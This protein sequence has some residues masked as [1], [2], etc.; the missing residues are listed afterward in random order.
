[1]SARSIRRSHQRRLRRVATATGAALGGSAL[2]ASGAQAVN[3]PVSNTNNAGAGS[4][5]GAILAANAAGGPDTISFNAGVSGEITLTTGEIPITDDLTITGPGAG[6]LSVSG[7]ANNNNVRDFATGAG[8]L[9][10]SR[11]F[12][13]DDPSAPGA[14][15]MRVTISGLTLREGVADDWVAGIQARPGGAIY[16]EDTDL[17]L[18][19]TTMSD[20]VATDDGG[21]LFAGEAD[22]SSA[23]LSITGSQFTANRALSEGGAV[24]SFVPKY[25]F[26]DEGTQITDTVISGNR[27]GGNDFGGVT[28]S[29]NPEGGGVLA[30]YS[31]EVTRVTIANNVA[32]T[33]ATDGSAGGI[34]IGTGS[35]TDSVVSGNSAGEDGG[36]ARFR[37][38]KVRGTTIS[39]NTAGEAAGGAIM[40]PGFGKYGLSGPA[41]LD[42]STVSGNSV[43]AAGVYGGGG[44]LAVYSLPDDAGL[45]V[46]NSTIAGNSA[47]R[48]AGVFTLSEVPP[49]EANVQLRNT[50]VADNSGSADLSGVTGDGMG[51]PIP[52]TGAFQAGFSLIENPGDV[53]LIGDPSASN[54]IGVDPQLAAL[55]ANGGPT[56]THA[57][58]PTSPAVDAGTAGTFTTDQRGQ[59]RTVDAAATNTP[60]TDGTDIGAYELADAAASGDD[61]ETTITK[62]PKKKLKLKGGK[63]TVKVK[64]K[65]TGTDNAP[66]PGSLSF[67]CSID[68]EPFADCRSPLKLEFG[69]GKHTIQVRAVDDSGQVDATPAVAKTKVKKAKAKGGKKK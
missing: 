6:V 44:G 19:N 54:L 21:A 39:G 41:R 59:A 16:A 25:E 32:L 4:L 23:R 64:V 10:D 45:I 52:S 5:R 40:S 56:Q 57:L 66:P 9:G 8:A 34:S 53:G 55:S 22:A 61:P 67:E 17:R 30:K 18:N 37:G 68:K 2:L 20:N 60:L 14:P 46:R 69:K 49:Y 62:K 7:D 35:V 51:G 15:L 13:I 63:K 3:F 65:F 38:T 33:G 29:T 43:V 31:G 27:A 42:S 47:S 12:T 26:G 24:A 1:M 11:I 36:G 58:S 28:P 48:G 50:I